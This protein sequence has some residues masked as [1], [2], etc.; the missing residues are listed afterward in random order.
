MIVRS[1]PGGVEGIEPEMGRLSYSETIKLAQFK[2]NLVDYLA[3]YEYGQGDKFA[4]KP[5]ELKKL[6]LVAFVQDSETQEVLQTAAIPVTGTLDYRAEKK[7][8]EKET[9]QESPTEKPVEPSSTKPSSSKSAPEAPQ[10]PTLKA[11]ETN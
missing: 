11:P 9:K 6:H 7:P 5:L 4:A 8:A 2:Q 1:M 3:D 10:G